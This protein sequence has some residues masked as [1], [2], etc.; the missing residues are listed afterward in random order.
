MLL[1]AGL[2]VDAVDADGGRALEAEA[3][4]LLVVIDADIF[5]RYVDAGAGKDLSQEALGRLVIGAAIEREKLD[6]DG[7]GMIG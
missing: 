2:H 4:G 5:D 3:K 1:A 6:V 7:R